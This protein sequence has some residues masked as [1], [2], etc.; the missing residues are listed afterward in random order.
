M[1]SNATQH[2]PLAN[3]C[4]E[5]AWFKS[6]YSSQDNGNCIEIADARA[7]GGIAIRDSKNPTGPVLVVS[8]QA[9]A[10]FVDARRDHQ[11]R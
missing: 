8:I 9:F 5:L 3:H 11:D 6:S 10:D 7:H 1:T 2:G 4:T